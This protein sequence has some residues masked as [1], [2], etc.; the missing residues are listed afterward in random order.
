VG[1]RRE[2]SKD[3]PLYLAGA[4]ADDDLAGREEAEHLDGDLVEA[5]T[6]VRQAA[7]A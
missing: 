3:V 6:S 5:A 2:G 7:K 1:Q 4:A